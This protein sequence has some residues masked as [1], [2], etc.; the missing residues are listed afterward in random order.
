MTS[1]YRQCVVARFPSST[2][3]AA[4]TN[5][6]LHTL[7]NHAPRAC[8]A[9]ITS[10]TRGSNWVP[11]HRASSAMAAPWGSAARYGRDV[12]IAL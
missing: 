5:D 1:A 8:A 4:I 11:A 9:R 10:V 3:D 7:S 2:P 12:V 6:P